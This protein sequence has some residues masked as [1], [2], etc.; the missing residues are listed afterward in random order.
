MK[1]IADSET[2]L[3]IISFVVFGGI[4]RLQLLFIEKNTQEHLACVFFST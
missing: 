2:F 1:D 3:S 4:I